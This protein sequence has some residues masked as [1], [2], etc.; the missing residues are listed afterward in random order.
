MKE[1][2]KPDRDAM[3]RRLRQLEEAARPLEPN[4]ERREELRQVVVEASE[5][6][7]ENVDQLPGFLELEEPGKG[8]LSA[9]LSE[10]GMPI[11]EA[12]GLVEQHVIPPGTNPASPGHLAFI[13]NGGLYH[14]ALADYYSAVTNKYGGIFYAG[15]G[16]VRME[17]LLLRWVADL[18]GY[19]ATAG[20]AILSGGS[21]SNLTA[22]TA[23]R[24][25]HGLRSVDVPQA[26]VYAT[27]QAHHAI[28]K[29]LHIAGMAEAPWR[30]VPMDG[31]YRMSAAALEEAIAADR[32]CG[33]RPW[34]IAANAG[35]T[36]TGAVD[37]LNALADIAEEHDCWLHVDAAYGGF[38]LLT[39][40]GRRLMAGIERSHSAVLDP[41]KTLFLPWG[42]GIV[43]VR[44]VATLAAA[45][46]ASGAYMQDAAKV[47]EISPA[48]ISPELTKPFRA[49]R[50]W[51]PL[52]ELGLAPFRAALEEKLLLARYFYD[53][54]KALG[55]EVGPP[56]D[57]S[58]VT[59]RWVP[60]GAEAEEVDR[61]NREISDAVKAEGSVYLS[62]TTLEGRFSLRMA[63]VGHRSH[64]AIVERA[65]EVLK[66]QVA[67]LTG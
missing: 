19:P 42:A 27:A 63:V 29:A 60:P 36:D 34:L 57:L 16:L 33:L 53:E 47:G 52:M 44:D 26:V 28:H 54:V 67:K 15:P 14:S 40:D 37:P 38:F 13:S 59:F 8:I 56:P 49:L 9:T 3:R 64:L 58:I 39:E 5:R 51:L 62:S 17:N 11:G 66:E 12:L 31:R 25:A 24:D 45:H 10:H 21:L 65:L 55:F 7:L 4:A 32:A 23:A 22:I 48:D 46:G 41:H 1:N 20:G 35:T 6:F 18:L 30:I 61:L 43:V 50:I 2:L